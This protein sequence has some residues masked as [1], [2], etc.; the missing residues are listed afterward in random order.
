MV[1]DSQDGTLSSYAS[2]KPSAKPAPKKSNKAEEMGAKQREISVAEFFEKNRHLLGFDNKRKSLL[3]TVKE[4]VDNSLDACE[5]AGILPE[6]QVELTEMGNDRYRIVVEDN[7]PG[8]VRKQIPKIFAKLLYGSKFHSLKQSL[9]ADQLVMVEKDGEVTLEPIGSL[10]DSFCVGEGEVDITKERWRVPCFDWQKHEYRFRPVSHVI[11][12]K[13]ANE[14]VELKTRYGKSIKVTGCHSLFTLDP[15]TMEVKEVA[16]RDLEEGS[17]V[18]APK[19]LPEPE[20]KDRV[21]VL[22]ELS[23]DVLDKC[24]WYVYGDRKAIRDLFGHAAATHKK[25]GE[26]KSRK[27][28]RFDVDGETVEVLDD[29]YKQYASKGFVPAGLAKR[30]S[31]LLGEGFFEGAK[32]RSYHHGKPYE[33]PVV[34]PL[35]KSLMGF[36]GL[37]VAEGHTDS[38]QVGLTFGRD[39]KELVAKVQSFAL[40]YGLS[41]TLEDRPGKNSLRV[42]L[43]GGILSTLLRRWCGHRAENKRVP[44]FVFSSSRELRQAFIDHLYLGD[45]HR[46]PGRNALMHSTVSERLAD[47]LNYLWLMQGVHA[48]KYEKPGGTLGR[49]RRPAYATSVYGSN[50]GDGEFFSEGSTK[51]S[52]TG[53]FVRKWLSANGLGSTEE[54]ADAYKGLFSGVEEGFSYDADELGTLTGSRKPGYKIRHMVEQGVLVRAG[55]S[56]MLT[57][58]GALVQGRLRGLLRFAQSDLT[59]LEVTSSRVHDEGEEWVYD[60]SVPGGENFVGGVGGISCHNSRGQQGIG[61]SASVMYGQL[62]TGRAAKITSKIDPDQPAHHYELKLNTQR[63]EPEILLDEEKQWSGKDHGTRIQIDLEAT[64]QKGQQSVD[65]YLKETAVINPHVTIIYMNPKAEQFIFPRAVEELPEMPKEVK[66]HPYGVEL[67]MLMKMLQWTKARTVKQFLRED[68]SRV[69][70]KAADEI[71]ENARLIPKKKPKQV[72]RDEAEALIRGI[73]DTRLMMPP[74]DCISPIGEDKLVKGLKKEINAEF[75]AAC[76]RPPA[77]YRGNPFVIEVALAYG[78]NQPGDKAVRLMRF[79]NKV[80]LLYQQGA[81]ATTDSIAKTSWKPYGLQQSG[82]NLPQGAATILVHMASGWVP[83]TSEAKEAMAHYP[84]IVKEI[85]LALQDIGRKLGKYT[86]KKR[87]VRDEMKKRSYIEKY[88]PHFAGA[89]KD[90]LELSDN[91]KGLLEDE[92]KGLLEHQRGKVD[93]LEFDPSK[94]TEYDE[95]LA[96]IGKE[97]AVEEGDE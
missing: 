6:I 29:S 36:L 33:V 80:P 50:L 12:H 43:F 28:Y 20:L 72:S 38:R 64:F 62:T 26:G 17:A 8:I 30:L 95:E 32:L 4:A 22:D 78:G 97:E 5:E 41:V 57:G 19:R 94:N 55:D 49:T 2:K 92:L 47:E 77:V 88:I 76:T 65:E 90:I 84:E 48:A 52:L 93:T 18:I 56:F 63:N 89:L 60:L 59:L 68:F 66:P 58:K 69:G 85:K 13:R 42:K 34:W 51:A 86:A 7:G 70:D 35:T 82:N 54:H 23:Q 10:V 14:I 11:K 45:G 79:A 15:K 39:E 27:Y 61:I 40:E 21:N 73:R 75:Y 46:V 9:T 1:Q 74:T 3:T 37:F 83:F 67:G 16:A 24:G 44:R 25:K 71:L 96:S 87:R 81:C 91:E 31:G 53:R